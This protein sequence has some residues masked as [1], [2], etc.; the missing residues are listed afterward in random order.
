MG[1]SQ[2]QN[3]WWWLAGAVVRAVKAVGGRMVFLVVLVD[4]PLAKGNY[5][6]CVVLG[7]QR[8]SCEWGK[9]PSQ[10]TRQMGDIWTLDQRTMGSL[11]CI[12]QQ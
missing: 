12:C 2:P 6:V 1:S 3:A 5:W 8:A 7:Y 9:A 4:A 10:A 11:F